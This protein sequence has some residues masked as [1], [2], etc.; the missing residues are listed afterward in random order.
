MVLP[1]H[2]LK[3]AA[4]IAQ[5][6]LGDHIVVAQH[7][8]RKPVP[9][10]SSGEIAWNL[11]PLTKRHSGLVLTFDTLNAL[12]CQ[13]RAPEA[14]MRVAGGKLHGVEC[15]HRSTPNKPPAPKKGA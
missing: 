15:T 13:S 9:H 4:F 8:S 10:K 12:A 5:N 1:T 6:R 7:P 3:M 2:S 11:G 14:R